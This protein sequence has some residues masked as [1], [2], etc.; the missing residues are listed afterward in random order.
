MRVCGGFWL[1]RLLRGRG[2]VPSV[3]ARLIGGDAGEDTVGGPDVVVAGLVEVVE[4]E[5]GVVQ[6]DVARNAVG[7][8]EVLHPDAVQV[9]QTEVPL[10]DVLVGRLIQRDPPA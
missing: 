5:Y 1:M 10:E 8:G 9:V 2:D 6:R 3:D 7:A 4:V